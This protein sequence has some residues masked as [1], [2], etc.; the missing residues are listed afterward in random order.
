MTIKTEVFD[1]T[2]IRTYSDSNKMIRSVDTGIEYVDAV[3]PI[4]EKR[5]YLETISPINIQNNEIA[6][7]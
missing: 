1:A 5:K 2:H 6:P 7:A 3:D 4:G